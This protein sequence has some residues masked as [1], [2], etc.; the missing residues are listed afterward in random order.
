MSSAPLV[1]VIVSPLSLFANWMTA[2]LPAFM[3]AWR[4]DPGPLSLVF[5]T[6]LSS[7]RPSSASGRGTYRSRADER[8]EDRGLHPNQIDALAS[9]ASCRVALVNS[10]LNGE[11]KNGDARG[12]GHGARTNPDRSKRSAVQIAASLDA[13]AHDERDVPPSRRAPEVHGPRRSKSGLSRQAVPER[14]QRSRAKSR[15]RS[16]KIKPRQILN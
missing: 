11:R 5:V 9:P 7:V 14:Y 2:P 4:S 10:F 6:V 3:I 1:S 16:S 12:T 13:T 8:R 15:A